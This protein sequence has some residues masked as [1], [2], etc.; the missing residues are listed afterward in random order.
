MAGQ[1]KRGERERQN[2]IESWRW[3]EGEERG[4]ERRGR[5]GKDLSVRMLVEITRISL[6]E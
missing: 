1:I 5:R 3:K 6:D 2:E 4:K